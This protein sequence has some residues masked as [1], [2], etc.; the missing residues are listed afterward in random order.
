MYGSD[1]IADSAKPFCK[2]VS[3][4]VTIRP[5]SKQH[6][7]LF[8]SIAPFKEVPFG[9]EVLLKTAIMQSY[10]SSDSLPRPSPDATGNLS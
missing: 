8:F 6:V 4:Y 7:Q 3:K 1:T 10:L 5:T 9:G 2:Y